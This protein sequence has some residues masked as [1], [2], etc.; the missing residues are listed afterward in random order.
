[1][2]HTRP[3]LLQNGCALALLAAAEHGV[4]RRA[5]AERRNRRELGDMRLRELATTDGREAGR[6]LAESRFRWDRTT[7]LLEELF[8]RAA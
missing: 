8:A 3:V 1:M 4:E 5:D 6:A 7:L 2:C